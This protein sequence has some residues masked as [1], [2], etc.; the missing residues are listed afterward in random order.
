MT[1]ITVVDIIYEILRSKLDAFSAH[2]PSPTKTILPELE[3]KHQ[4][5]DLKKQE[6][7]AAAR[8]PK[9]ATFRTS[10]EFG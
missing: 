1:F 2:L 3:L 5:F 10:L 4:N 6:N 7:S 8:S 9:I